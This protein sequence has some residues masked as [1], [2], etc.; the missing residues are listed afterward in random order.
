MWDPLAPV[1]QSLSTPTPESPLLL[2]LSPVDTPKG[3]DIEGPQPQVTLPR[4]HLIGPDWVTCSP[5][6]QS[7]TAPGGW[8]VLSRES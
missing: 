7:A 2:V 1:W 3:G 8:V 4:E 5:L 6:I